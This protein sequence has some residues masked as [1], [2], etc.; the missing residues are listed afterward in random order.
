MKKNSDPTTLPPIIVNG[1]FVLGLLSALS[2]RVLMICYRLY[3]QWVRPVWYFGVIGYVLFFFY[4]FLI[5]RKRKGVIR[6]NDLL[7]KIESRQ[8]LSE[9]DNKAVLY[10]LQSIDRSKEMWNYA[11]IFIL[12]VLA[13]AVDLILA[14]VKN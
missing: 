8:N 2:I 7:K 9:E 13:I 6:E 5:A 4:R 1:F 12:S 3:P 10:L 11:N 14:A